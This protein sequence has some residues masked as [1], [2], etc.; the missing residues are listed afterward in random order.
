MYSGP[1]MTRV[2]G[3]SD[4]SA[5]SAGALGC[6]GCAGGGG[7]GI[8]EVDGVVVASLGAAGVAAGAEAV[9]PGVFWGAS[10]DDE[11]EDEGPVAVGG[12]VSS[13]VGT[14]PAGTLFLSYL[15]PRL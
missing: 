13:E 14:P 6:G 11:E 12:A 7:A 15:Q 8:V 3:S 10:A 9:R 4:P 1:S 5:D 2:S